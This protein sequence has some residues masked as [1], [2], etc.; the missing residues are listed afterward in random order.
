[1][2][3][4]ERKYQENKCSIMLS[5]HTGNLEQGNNEKIWPI[6]GTF[7]ASA[8]LIFLQCYIPSNRSHGYSQDS[9]GRFTL[10]NCLDRARKMKNHS[11]KEIKGSEKNPRL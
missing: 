5:C 10:S 2:G 6:K 3:S 9:K 1:M 7:L 8:S 11:K 4:L